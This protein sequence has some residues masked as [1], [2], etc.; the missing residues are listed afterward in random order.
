MF[1]IVRA[2]AES[3][4]NAQSGVDVESLCPIG[5]NEFDG[6]RPFPIDSILTGIGIDAV[7]RIKEISEIGDNRVS[8]DSLEIGSHA[9]AIKGIVHY[10]GI[11]TVIDHICAPARGPT[12][13]RRAIGRLTNHIVDEDVGFGVDIGWSEPGLEGGGAQDG[14]LV[15]V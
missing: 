10:I 13:R 11:H 12:R 15:D 7:G 6:G 3:A 2:A 5:I 9:R 8:G 14:R 1:R 4:A